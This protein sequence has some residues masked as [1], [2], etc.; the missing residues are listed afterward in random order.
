MCVYCLFDGERGENGGHDGPYSGIGKETTRTDSAERLP[1]CYVVRRI[2]SP[3]SKPKGG[4]KVGILDERTVRR[5]EPFGSEDI[6]VAIDSRIM[7]YGPV[8]RL[9]MGKHTGNAM[10]ELPTINNDL[11]A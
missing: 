1:V 4:Y 3:S 9:N 5:Q 8:M 6:W 7:E 10:C 11:R 2:N